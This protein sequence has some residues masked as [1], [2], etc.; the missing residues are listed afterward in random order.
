MGQRVLSEFEEGTTP[1]TTT[2]DY[3]VAL[4]LDARCF[5]NGTIIIKNT[6]ATAVMTYKIDGYANLAGT[7]SIADVSATDINGL[8]S[9]T[10]ERNPVKARGKIVVSVKSKVT[11]TPATYVIE[12]IQGI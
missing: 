10:Y 9:A 8:A 4:T 2:D 3:V 6:H 12:Y 7:T 1:G 11:S 5:R